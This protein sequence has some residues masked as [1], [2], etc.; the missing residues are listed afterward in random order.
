MKC[1][2]VYKLSCSELRIERTFYKDSSIPFVPNIGM[3]MVVDDVPTHVISLSWWQEM[4]TLT[5][6]LRG[7]N[8]DTE[9][10]LIIAADAWISDDWRED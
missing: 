7:S 2:F 5:V 10:D 3:N 9:D 6:H 4:A 8:H 1:T